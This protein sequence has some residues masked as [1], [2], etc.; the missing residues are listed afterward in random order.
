M[1]NV[2]NAGSGLG[3]LV[4][5]VGVALQHPTQVLTVKTSVKMLG[6]HACLANDVIVVIPIHV[7]VEVFRHFPFGFD[8]VQRQGG[9]YWFDVQLQTGKQIVKRVLVS[10]WSLM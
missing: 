3:G 8:V 10:P 1:G 9:E 4:H 5:L 7:E 2:K 6:M